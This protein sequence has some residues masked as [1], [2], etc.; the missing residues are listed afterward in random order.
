MTSLGCALD[1]MGATSSSGVTFA[2]ACHR[3]MA[4]D[5]SFLFFHHHGEHYRDSQVSVILSMFSED[6]EG[7]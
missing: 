3:H 6:P 4:W 2:G 5:S 1:Q 7:L